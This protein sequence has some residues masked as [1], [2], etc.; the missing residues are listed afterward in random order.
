MV[1]RTGSKS[2]LWSGSDRANL[3]RISI[4]FGNTLTVLYTLTQSYTVVWTTEC[5]TQINTVN[6]AFLQRNLEKLLE[7]SGK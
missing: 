1:L 3:T 6:L 4:K 7:K 2:N 5:S